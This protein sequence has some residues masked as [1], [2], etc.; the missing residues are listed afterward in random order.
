[1][2]FDPN[3]LMP[4]ALSGKDG[5]VLTG[6][7][8]LRSR[9]DELPELKHCQTATLTAT[10]KH[11]GSLLLLRMQPYFE[12]ISHDDSCAYCTGRR[13]AT[14]LPD[15][16]DAIYCISLQ[17]Q[18]HR[19]RQAIAHFH[20]IGLCR[21]V[22]FYRPT[23]GKNADHAIWASHRAVARHVLSNGQRHA[24]VLEDDVFFRRSWS[25]LAPR[26]ARAM[27]AL[28][29]NWL[30][31]YLGH[32]PIQ[33]FFVRSNIMRVRSACTHAYIAGPR[34]LSWLAQTEP[35]SANVATWPLIGHSIDGA[36][37]NLPGM[38]A[39]FPMA[40][41]QQFLG[42]YRVDTRVDAH[43]RPRSWRDGDRWRY[44]FIFRGA[45]MVEALAAITSPFH[46]LTLERNRERSS[47]GQTTD[48]ISAAGLCDDGFL[49]SPDMTHGPSPFPSRANECGP[50]RPR[51]RRYVPNSASSCAYCTGRRLATHLPDTLDAIYCISLQEQPHRTRQA[52]A[53]FHSIGL[54]R[55]V[56]FYR[57]TRGKNADHAIWASHRAVARH[58]LS[59][60]QRHALVL[61][62]DVFFRRSWSNLAPRIARAMAALPPNWLCFY[63]GHI[64]IQ[65]F[66]VRS[67]IMRVRSACTHAYIAGPRLLSWLAQ[68]EPL[69][70]NVATWPLIGHSI[71]GAMANLPGMYA[72][73]PMAIRQ[74]F[75][76]DYRVDTRVDAH[77]RP[78]SWRDGDRWRYYFIFR[79]ALM[80]E[81]LA[82][83]T[84]P[85]HRLTLERNRERSSTGQTTDLIS[86]AGLCDDGF[87]QSPDM[88][89]G[90]SPF[91]SRA[92]ECG[93]PRP[94]VRRYVPNSAS[95]MN[96]VAA[97]PIA[98]TSS[99][100]PR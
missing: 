67:N 2:S 85:F 75:L 80:V 47:T 16:L 97:Y 27:A 11:R 5:G 55:C 32:I 84:S 29:P 96:A 39:L 24:L 4:R 42:D 14:H 69:S 35:L 26:I 87:L 13:L 82:A 31:F 46:R 9:T 25:N 70:A 54:C 23:R 10:I 99:G 78:R 18:P 3:H 89:H 74:R 59:N 81:A 36:M 94:R 76:G 1:M 68:T 12:R 58:V 100:L 51:V 15:T 6:A 49:Q 22:I 61:E 38:Y 93:P 73:F 34:L 56:I 8:T 98:R 52:I 63:L 45:L 91:P 66:F 19:T 92:N 57:P 60:G 30:C 65:A 72:L 33:A 53:H 95:E 44:Y 90:P 79:G 86:A 20:S 88:T 64:P 62:D 21:C 71:D 77:G 37:A 41:R 40:I 83:I 43:G 50:P 17:E 48:L 28:P 7:Y